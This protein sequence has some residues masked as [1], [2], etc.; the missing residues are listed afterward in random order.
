MIRSAVSNDL[1][2]LEGVE[3]S[4]ARKFA[5]L[6]GYDPSSST[7]PHEILQAS[8]ANQ[9]LWI[10]EY[11]GVPVGFLA[12]LNIDDGLHVEELSVALEFQGQGRGG[13]LLKAA[14][15]YAHQNEYRAVTLTTNSQIPWN[16][17]FYTRAGFKEISVNDC[18]SGLRE[19]LLRDKAKSFK[20]EDRIAMVYPINS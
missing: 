5:H 2:F 17:P 16:A 12:A 18:K 13:A 14:M 10:S 7:L 3:R 11:D 6:E 19:I 20:P 8:L 9:H 4:A 15:E 1:A